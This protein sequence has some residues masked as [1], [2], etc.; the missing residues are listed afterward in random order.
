MLNM[1]RGRGNSKAGF[2]LIELLVV[3]A[4]IAILIALILPA[5]Q[6]AREAARRTQCRN[7]MKQLVLALHNY[8]GTHMVLPASRLYPK[9]VIH[10]NPGSDPLYPNLSSYQS[11][12]TMVLPHIDQANLQ[13]DLDFNYAWHAA[14]NRHAISH[15]VSTFVC[16]SAPSSDRTD[17]NWVVGAAAGDY[18]NITEVKK[19]VYSQVLGLPEPSEAS[20]AGVLS[21]GY[22]NKF[23]HV[24]DGAS[25]TIC[26]AEVAGQPFIWTSEG[27]MNADRFAAYTDD[28]VVDLGGT[29]VSADGTGWADP[30]N[31]FAI[32]G[33]TKDGL[34]KYS[35]YMINR[36]NTSEVFSFH[37]G[38]AV[39]ALA[40]GSVRFV[41]ESI[42]TKVFVDA[43]TRAG[44]EIQGQW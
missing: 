42:D 18:N 44:G 33:A 1:F 9:S 11:W 32:N 16:P 43:C 41:S 14:E 40:D 26:L 3:I 10:D 13:H 4:I 39:V 34:T 30:D 36:I 38:G 21:K 24:R 20:R 5:V 29:Y 25:N 2:T 6:Q 23:A 37:P 15:Q 27:Q 28:K 8:E 31:G 19:K 7:N 22:A 35:T 12:T 17:P